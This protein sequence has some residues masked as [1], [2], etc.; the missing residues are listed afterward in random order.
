MG[1]EHFPGLDEWRERVARELP[2]W[3]A[4]MLPVFAP[5]Q[6]RLWNVGL[7]TAKFAGADVRQRVEYSGEDQDAVVRAAHDFRRGAG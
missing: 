4:G 7:T 5:E 1:K 3:T 2:G 6:I